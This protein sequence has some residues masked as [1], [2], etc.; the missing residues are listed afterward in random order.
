MG[1]FLDIKYTEQREPMKITWNQRLN[2]NIHKL[3]KDNIAPIGIN[4][5][6][7]IYKELYE[8]HYATKLEEFDRFVETEKASMRAPRM[9]TNNPRDIPSTSTKPNTLDGARR[10]MER[11]NEEN[12]PRNK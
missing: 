8:N 4:I 11:G 5:Y 9:C 12:K 1:P 10:S 3:P 2:N 6:W 7:R